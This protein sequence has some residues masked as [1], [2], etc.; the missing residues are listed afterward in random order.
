MAPNLETGVVLEVA[1]KTD[2]INA[3]DHVQK[4]VKI[5]ATK[6]ESVA[7]VETKADEAEAGIGT[8]GAAAKTGIAEVEV[9]IVHIAVLDQDLET[10]VVEKGVLPAGHLPGLVLEW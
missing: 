7:E 2:G 3:Q 10:G 5:G 9:A 6:T 1:V 4:T 8:S